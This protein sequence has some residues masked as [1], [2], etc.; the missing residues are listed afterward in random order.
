MASKTISLEQSA[1]ER[2]LAAKRQGESFSDV[3]NRLTTDKEPRLLDLVGLADAQVAHDLKG[4][5]HK[6]RA[7]Q[8]ALRRERWRRFGWVD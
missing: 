2:L 6:H 4:F 1:Y 8:E 7:E 5:I 3:V